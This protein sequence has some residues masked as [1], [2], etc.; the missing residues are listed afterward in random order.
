[1]GVLERG[2]FGNKALKNR[3]NETSKFACLCVSTNEVI[4]IRIVTALSSVRPVTAAHRTE[5]ISS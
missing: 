2:G 1:M 5:I 3:V 4:E